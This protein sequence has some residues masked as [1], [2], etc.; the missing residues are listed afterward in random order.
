MPHSPRASCLCNAYTA[1]TYTPHPDELTGGSGKPEAGQG[2]G[3]DAVAGLPFSPTTSQE[4]GLGALT[5]PEILSPHSYTAW[6]YS[7]F[8]TAILNKSAH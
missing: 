7:C 4:G 5:Q 6:C 3:M 2:L 1:Q 8:H